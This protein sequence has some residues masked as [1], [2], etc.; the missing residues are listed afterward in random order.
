MTSNETKMEQCESSRKQDRK[1]NRAKID[2]LFDKYG[3]MMKM[4]SNL[5]ETDFNIMDEKANEKEIKRSECKERLARQ[6]IKIHRYLVRHGYLE[7]DSNQDIDLETRPRIFITSSGNEELN[8]LLTKHINSVED[9][10]GITLKY[11][12]VHL[13]DILLMIEQIRSSSEIDPFPKDP[14]EFDQ[15]VQNIACNVNAEVKSELEK[16]HKKSLEDMELFYGK[17][18]MDKFTSLNGEEA[19]DSAGPSRVSWETVRMAITEAAVEGKLDIS[20]SEMKECD[21]DTADKTECSEEDG[22]ER[23]DHGTERTG[24]TDISADNLSLNAT[25]EGSD[26]NNSEGS[27]SIVE[28]NENENSGLNV[29]ES[30][31][32]FKHDLIDLVSE[33]D[34]RN[35]GSHINAEMSV[36][37]AKVKEKQD[38][39]EEAGCPES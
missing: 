21:I 36:S 13:D 1:R 18:D 30:R 4:I 32:D 27:S 39:A 8:Q 12:H 22:E 31:T 25:S 9:F 16:E 38:G 37:S 24:E 20:E 29:G 26:G 6:C 2:A 14:V 17:P 19:S 11:K 3:K 34:T 15:M 23:S 10:G 28:L 35:S 33:E 5:E 7:G